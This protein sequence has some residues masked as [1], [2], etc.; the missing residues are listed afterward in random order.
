MKRLNKEQKIE[1]HELVEDYINV[2]DTNDEEL[3]DNFEEKYIQPYEDKYDEVKDIH[4]MK[5]TN[6]KVSNEVRFVGLSKLI[7]K[8]KLKSLEE[9]YS[10]YRGGE[11]EYGS[12]SIDK[13]TAKAF[14]KPFYSGFYDTSTTGSLRY[15][16][17]EKEITIK[18]VDMYYNN[19]ESEIILK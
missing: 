4:Y 11:T 14:T 13:D 17:W 15:P 6:P 16:L 2:L 18:D 3:I 9:R 12:Y 7:L 10:I 1:L 19:S 5:N 8:L